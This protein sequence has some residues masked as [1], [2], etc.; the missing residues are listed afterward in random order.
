LP[1]CASSRSGWFLSRLER[2]D[3]RSRLTPA[4]YR[5]SEQLR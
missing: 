5:P 4:S 1:T 2:S 3:G